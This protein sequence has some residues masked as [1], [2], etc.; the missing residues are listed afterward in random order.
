LKAASDGNIPLIAVGLLYQEGYF[1]QIMS[2]EGNQVAMPDVMDM[3]MLPLYRINDS[4]GAPLQISIAFPG[5]TITAGVWKV[6]VGRVALYLLDTNVDTNRPEDRRICAKLYNSN[7]ELR[8]QQEILLGIGGVR[9]LTALNIHPD[10][11]HINE[12]HAAFTAFERIGE[13]IQHAHL[14]FDEALEVIKASSQFTTHT[15]V[16]AA[17][18]LFDEVQLRAYLSYLAR[19]FNISWERLMALGQA[20]GGQEKFSMFYLAAHLSQEINAVSRLHRQVSCRLLQQL[21]KDFR[22]GELHI[23]SVTNGVHLPTWT[24]VQWQHLKKDSKSSIQ[25]IPASRIWA[26]RQSL[27]QEMLQGIRSRL[28]TTFISTNNADARLRVLD[29]LK[30]N[31]LLIGFARR[32][33]PYKRAHLLFTD[34]QR[35]AAIL[36]NAARPVRIIFAGKAHPDD[37]EGAALIKKVILASRQP[38]VSN[39]ILFLEDYDMELGALLVKGVDVWL[40]T[41]RLEREACGTSGMKAVLNGVLHCSVKDGWWAEAYREGAGWALEGSYSFEQD[42]L[43]DTQDAAL[44]YSMLEN[45]I[46]PLFYERNSGGLPEGWINMIRKSLSEVAPGC[47]MQRV[48]KEYGACY[49][50]LY[51]RSRALQAEKYTLAKELTVWKKKMLAAWPE[52]HVMAIGL[53]DGDSKMQRLGESFRITITLCIGS[54]SV[55]DLGVEIVVSD[56]V[57]TNDY[58]HVQPLPVTATNGNKLT[59]SDKVS[60]MFSGSYSYS[61]RVFAKHPALP[62]RMDFPL[63]TWI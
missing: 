44:L 31:V 43:Q 54:L 29:D 63:I 47:D 49:E 8:L 53:P 22:P 16:A 34:L 52:I 57:H 9:L 19:D 11:F 30:N 38:E 36:N 39:H 37:G 7:S 17:M 5:R 42:A 33:A 50:K 18:D 61:F 3:G 32:F 41:P 4:T 21:W 23:T 56:A 28:H 62:H 51:S 20:D 24:A 1:K 35:L 15:A 55:N 27:K 58:L 14:D 10:V 2:P 12:G 59:F 46:V 26:V 60:L 13:L 48:V 6:S 25:H 45:D 40:N